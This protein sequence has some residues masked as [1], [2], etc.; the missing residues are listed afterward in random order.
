MLF[1][2]ATVAQN[3][4]VISEEQILHTGLGVKD[5]PLAQN[6]FYVGMKNKAFSPPFLKT[7]QMISQHKHSARKLTNKCCLC[8]IFANLDQK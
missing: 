6:L 4:E 1:Y 8:F 5:C 2:K 3:F 7:T